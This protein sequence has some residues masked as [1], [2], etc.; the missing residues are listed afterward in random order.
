[1]VK[2]LNKKQR[3][4]KKIKKANKSIKVGRIRY[5]PNSP[6]VIIEIINKLNEITEEVYK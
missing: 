1:M 2:K 3:E 6:E 4:K 5:K